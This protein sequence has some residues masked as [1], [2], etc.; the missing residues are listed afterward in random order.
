[1]Y[2]VNF[3]FV[4]LVGGGNEEPGWRGFALPG[5]QEKY[6]PLISSL[7]LGPIWL[8]WRVPL[9]F[10]PYTSQSVIPF[11]W[12]VPN[13]I[14]IAIITTWLYNGT[15]RSVLLASMLHAGLNALAAFYPCMINIG[16]FPAYAFLTMGAW[17]IVTFIF[18]MDRAALTGLVKTEI[19]MTG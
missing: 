14:G 19:K 18:L 3:I 7:I 4:L 16:P 12:Y 15:S 8:L 6:G 13:I 1:M 2:P 17:I 9:F 5:I 10:S 11:E